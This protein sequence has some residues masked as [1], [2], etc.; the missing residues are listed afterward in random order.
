MEIKDYWFALKSHVYVEFKQDEILLYDTK[1]GFHIETDVKDI[2]SFVKQLYEPKNLGVTL[3]SKEMQSN[4]NIRSFLRDVLKKQ[5]GD[6]T[7]VE[8]LPNKPVR[9]I[10]ILNLQK[11]V[12]R[13]KKNEENYLLIGNNA[14]D[15]LLELNIFLNNVCSLI[16]SHC[17]KYYRQVNCCTTSNVNQ[18]LSFEDTESIFK[19]IQFSA[20]GKVNI[21]GGNIFEYRHITKLQPLFDSFK[22][23]LHCYFHYEN[24]RTKVLSDSLHFELIMNFPIKETIFRNTWNIINKEKT[25]VHFII[26]NE[27]Q[28]EDMENMIEKFSIEKYLIQPVFTGKNLIFFQENVF[29]DKEDLFSKTL[30]MREIFRNRKLNSNFFGTLYI[31][32]DGVVKANM[33]VPSIGNIKTDS[34]LDLIFKEM[35][36]NTAWRIVRDSQPCNEC[37]YQ[38]ICPAPSNFEIVIG[39]SNLCNVKPVASKKKEI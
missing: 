10:P 38:Y 30:S 19:Q 1:S 11:D 29:I 25:T 31:L 13:L 17:D 32:P 6:L 2:I 4:L 7:D 3:L 39:C 26:E 22:E 21:L 12:D 36:D 20:V 27:E 18:E 35:I 34:L 37:I 24:Y 16:C 33:N 14:K 23:I 8:K 5:M 9:L 15:Y 28:Y